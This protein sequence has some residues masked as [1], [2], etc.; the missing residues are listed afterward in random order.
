MLSRIAARLFWFGR[1]VERADM[2]ARLLI[3][4]LSLP[5]ED[6]WHDREDASRLLAD[7]LGIAPPAGSAGAD[8]VS[9]L[10][11]D[12]RHPASVT[13]VLSLAR[14]AARGLVGTL[15]SEAVDATNITATAVADARSGARDRPID[16]LR[17]LLVHTAALGGFLD[18]GMP[19]DPAFGYLRLGQQLERADMV[20]RLLLSRLDDP[21][22][23]AVWACTLEACAG[24]EAFTRG[25]DGSLGSLGRSAAVRFLTFSRAFPRAVLA[26]L[27]AALDAL[28]LVH[29]TFG[30][31]E[32]S[33]RSRTVP[34]NAAEVSLR[35]TIDLLDAAALGSSDGPSSK[36][37]G[38][39]TVA[40][41]D[42]EEFAGLLQ[43]VVRTS[44]RVSDALS[45]TDFHLS[46]LLW[47]HDHVD[48]GSTSPGSTGPG[49]SDPGATIAG[50]WSEPLL[51][52][53]RQP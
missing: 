49:S 21:D 46:G 35:T 48:P 38:A 10:V 51:L 23:P 36:E 2:T 31:L 16:L 8:L 6:P 45:A 18:G 14:D 39:A 17:G 41:F 43:G 50:P 20:A 28:V 15:P 1:Y 4:G 40:P 52:G 34:P 42:R 27:V 7:A 5:F 12:E 13:R 47:R 19:R 29:P 9:L 26:A 32:W 33:G 44:A 22:R 3:A 53:T 30:L 11:L 25:G 37:A 24:L